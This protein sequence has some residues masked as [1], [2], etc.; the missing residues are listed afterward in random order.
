MRLFV[1][2][3]AYVALILSVSVFL[4][5]CPDPEQAPESELDSMVLDS[6]GQ[7]EVSDSASAPDSDISD[8]PEAAADSD[9]DA[10]IEVPLEQ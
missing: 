7:D 1:G 2:T 3:L 6:E 10:D 9:L 5:G 8:A 4:G